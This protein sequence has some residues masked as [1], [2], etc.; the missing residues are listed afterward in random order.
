MNKYGQQHV[1]GS[2]EDGQEV[3]IT[4]R[5]TDVNKAFVSVGQICEAGHMVVFRKDGGE[6]IAPCKR[7]NGFK[8]VNG[9]YTMNI[10]V[11][12]NRVQCRRE[13]GTCVNCQD[14]QCLIYQKREWYEG[15]LYAALGMDEM[16][17]DPDDDEEG[18]SYLCQ[19]AN[20]GFTRQGYCNI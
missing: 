13:L 3:N 12:G 20:A 19:L 9:V 14:K 17:S 10:I 8:Q 1:N 2:R 16:E 5:V 6:R 11:K 18:Q 7:N 4:M 15:N